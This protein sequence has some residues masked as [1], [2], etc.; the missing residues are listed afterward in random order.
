MTNRKMGM[1]EYLHGLPLVECVI[2][3]SEKSGF[4]WMVR[5]NGIGEYDR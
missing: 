5:V 4:E 2:Y 1:E 3:D